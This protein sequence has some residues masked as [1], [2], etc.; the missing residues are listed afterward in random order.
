MGLEFLSRVRAATLVAAAV[1]TLFVAVY[2][3]PLWALAFALGC[4]WSLANLFAVEKLV[5]GLT[6]PGRTAARTLRQA[7]GSGLLLVAL[8]PL[9]ALL[10]ARFDAVALSVGFAAPYA[11]MMFKAASLA[12][13][14]SSLWRRFVQSPRDAARLVAI[15]ALLAWAARPLLAAAA[16]GVGHAAATGSGRE[17]ASQGTVGGAQELPN[18]VTLL[19]RALGEHHPVSRF[20]HTFEN[21]IFALLVSLIL[22]L[23]AYFA[24]RKATVGVPGA[25][26]NGVEWAVERLNDFVVGILGEKYGPRYVPYLGT[27]FV[28]ILFMNLFGLIPFMKSPT[29]NLNITF[30]LGLTTFLYVQ[31]EGVR[32]LGIVGYVDHLAGNPR[33]VLSWAL[34]PIMLPVHVL[35]ELAKPISLSC[36]LFGNIFGEDMLLVA[37]IGV[38]VSLLSFSHLPFGLPLQ[39]PFFIGLA[40]LSG[41]I[42]ALV[43]TVL[44]CIYF[45][46]MLPHEHEAEGHH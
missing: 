13:L 30:A 31:M 36:R 23:V 46:L 3:S 27:L 21:V 7:G 37:F 44:S 18:L 41:T 1:V 15:G 19:I 26:Q 39:W 10:L 28:Y 22:V 32:N 25:L 12:L 2:A 38:G 35:G 43:F 5:A 16:G 42:Q 45:L 20:L 40:M 4:A 29:S 17:G 34:V 14:G 33:S 8:F 9:G 6:T 11:V 24:S